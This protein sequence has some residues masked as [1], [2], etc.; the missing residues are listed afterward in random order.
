MPDTA[1]SCRGVVAS[2]G[3]TEVLHGLD[4]DVADGSLTTLT[5]PSGAGKTTLLRVI[6]GLERPRAGQVSLAGRDLDGVPPHRRRIAYV[7][8]QPRLFPNLDVVDNVAFPLRLA[9]VH[10]DE[11]R[12]RALALLE[13]VG[14]AQLADRS[15]R[16]L[17][18]GEAQR[19]SLAR[20]LCGEPDLVLLDE[21]LASVD[22]D[23]RQSLR[24]LV[25]Q[26]Q[27]HRRLTMLYVTHDQ[28]E[29]AELGD[30]LALMADG[31]IVQHG[32]PD[33][34]FERPA[35]AAVARFFGNGNRL[36]GDVVSG[37]LRLGPAAIPVP[38]PDGPATFTIRPQHVRFDPAS[39]LRG[40]AR[41]AT[42]LGTHARVVLSLHG[43]DLEAHVA[44]GDEPPAGVDVGVVLPPER[45][46]RLPTGADEP[47]QDEPPP[48]PPA[49]ELRVR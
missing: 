28:S 27:R 26:L 40:R 38:G 34:L 42:Y 29:A 22:A 19:V 4:L 13:E 32:A 17:S 35:T 1:L 21:P 49:A 18:G 6:A 16:R 20:A 45:L 46:W 11:R 47:A 9:G 24:A 5:G 14:L 8:Q 7:F 30:R 31:R 39:D 25:R 43:I 33:D 41:S 48:E 36:R 37:R 10:T 44:P 3:G 15:P 12:D 23:R 2:P